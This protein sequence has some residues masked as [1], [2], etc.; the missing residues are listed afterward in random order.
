MSI[1]EVMVCQVNMIVYDGPVLS[2][3][4][5]RDIYLKDGER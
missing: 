3:W 2:R 4:E 1:I 5:S